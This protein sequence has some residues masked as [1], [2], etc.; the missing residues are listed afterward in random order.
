MQ[1]S[2]F[3]DNSTP[4]EK[5]RTDGG[6]PLREGLRY[7]IVEGVI[8]A[9]KTS[10]T[11]LLAKQYRARVVHEMF[12]E[13]PFLE[14]FYADRQRWAFQTQLSFLA[15]R[16][17]QQHELLKPDLFHDVVISDY[18]FDKDRIFAHLNLQGDE[19]TLY[20]NLFRMMQTSV[21]KPDLV[22]YLQA[23]TD[24][25]MN[26]IA[27]R[28]RR[29]ES[30]MD[31]EYISSLNEAYNYYYFRYVDSPLLIV[32]ADKIDFVRNELERQELIRQIATATYP[33]TT[34]YNPIAS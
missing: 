27:Q 17:R 7:I 8:G 12:E 22:V 26:N 4:A 18:S 16:F 34:Y 20:E 19:L 3:Q 14:R 30:N 2:L 21:P 5:T 33:G 13:N 24:R 32:N 23:S 15:S 29:Y 1:E 25:L 9:G 11:D 10:L 31:R 28:G 6:P